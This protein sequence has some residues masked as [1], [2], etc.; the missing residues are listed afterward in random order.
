MK[1][2]YKALLTLALA[3]AV[4][5]P[6]SALGPLEWGAVAGVNVPNFNSPAKGIDMTSK[7]GWQVGVVTAIKF[8]GFAIEPQIFYVR[9]GLDLNSDAGGELKLKSN[10]IDVPVLFS[11]RML[12]PFRFYIGPVFTVMNDCKQKSGGDLLDFGRLR[13]TLAYTIGA[14]VKL[15]GHLL[16]DF[17]FN[18]QFRAKTDVVLPDGGE[19]GKLRCYNFALSL[20][21]LF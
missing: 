1:R 12:K 20:G 19:I 5:T 21:Y 7:L 9:Q 11:V 4:A 10:S 6:A 14:G 15:P 18:G 8:A 13:P 16:V 3:V 2:L 17:R